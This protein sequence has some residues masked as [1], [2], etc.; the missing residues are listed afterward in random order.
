MTTR[1]R[2]VLVLSMRHC[3]ETEKEARSGKTASYAMVATESMQ[4]A[5][6]PFRTSYTL[7]FDVKERNFLEL[8]R[9]VSTDIA[10][11]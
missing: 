11:R 10:N 2:K 4:I 1:E 3:G 8:L 9:A 7:S 5:P 6:K